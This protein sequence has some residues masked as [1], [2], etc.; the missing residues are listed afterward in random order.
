MQNDTTLP[1]PPAPCGYCRRCAVHDDPGGCLTVQAW[2]NANPE[3]AIAAIQAAGMAFGQ[4]RVDELRAVIDI[5]ARLDRSPVF[6]KLSP[7]LRQVVAVNAALSMTDP[8]DRAIAE[9]TVD[10]TF[11]GR[12]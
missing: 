4:Y 10:P 2:E 1:A 9:E 3:A 5:R 8:F 11:E 12:S 6:A 7:E